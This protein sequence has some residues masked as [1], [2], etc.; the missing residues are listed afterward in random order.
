MKGKRGR[1][2]PRPYPGKNSHE[3]LGWMLAAG[4]IALLLLLVGRYGW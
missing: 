1:K 2:T 3:R 4:V